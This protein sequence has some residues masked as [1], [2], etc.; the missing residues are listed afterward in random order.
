[1]QSPRYGVLACVN[2][3]GILNSWVRKLI[4]FQS[5]REISYPVL[6]LPFVRLVKAW[7]MLKNLFGSVG[8]IPEG[9]SATQALKNQRFVSKHKN[10]LAASLIRIAEFRNKHKYRPPYW[11]LVKL[12]REAYRK[13]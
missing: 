1:V 3:T 9:M 10:L 12:C 4:G 11:Q 8:I 7:C 13:Y 2:G 6:K 5:N